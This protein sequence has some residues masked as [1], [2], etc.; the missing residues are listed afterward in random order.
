LI[1]AGSLSGNF[2]S[3][4]GLDLGGGLSFE[5]NVSSTNVVLVAVDHRPALGAAGWLTNGEFQFSLTG[6][7]GS[8]YVIEASTDLA[9]WISVSTNVITA[10][11]FIPVADPL[12]TNFPQRFYRAV[13]W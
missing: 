12:A 11:G 6:Q 10:A 1:S 9:H 4:N 3:T 8:N 7:I 13:A 5:V 2:S